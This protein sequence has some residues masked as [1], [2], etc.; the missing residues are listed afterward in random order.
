MP[1]VVGVASALSLSERL[2]RRRQEKM[3]VQGDQPLAEGK[4]AGNVVT[5]ND[6]AAGQLHEPQAG[7]A[8]PAPGAPPSLSAL[9]ATRR[10]ARLGLAQ[11]QVKQEV[12][13]VL[14]CS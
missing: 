9:V 6:S 1:S 4:A 5:F 10:A 8:V 14:P 13:R 12:Q 11:Q 2:G 7:A 3:G